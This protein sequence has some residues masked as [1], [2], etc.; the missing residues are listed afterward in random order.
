[1]ETMNPLLVLAGCYTLL[2]LL[3]FW[4]WKMKSD[5]LLSHKVQSGNWTLLHLRHAGGLIFLVLF[6]LIFHKVISEG[7]LVW[8]QNISN[9]QVM[10][11]MVTGLVLLTMS[12]KE[13][14]GIKNKEN[15]QG[16]QSPFHAVLHMILRNSFLV[17]YEWFFR[18]VLLFTCVG[19]FGD[20]TAIIINIVL[21]AFIHSFNGK[22]EFLG[23]IPFGL[24]LCVFTL[25]W[26]SVWPAVILH[27]LLSS[28]YESVILHR[29]FCY[30]KKLVI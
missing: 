22:K 11:V 3:S 23:S 13:A 24:L 18:G 8:P 5:N 27:L 16:S 29:F 9:I 6:P 12:A 2:F 21:Y 30:L 26:Q 14:A 25:W 19:L 7:L 20:I 17:G 28:T 1:M 10:A 4:V 15:S